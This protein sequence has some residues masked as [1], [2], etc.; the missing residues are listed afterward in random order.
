MMRALDSDKCLE[1]QD[2]HYLQKYR[3]KNHV[4]AGNPCQTFG[5]ILKF[6]SHNLS[7]VEHTLNFGNG[8]LL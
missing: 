6:I 4:R 2:T 3:G 1:L 8:L 5:G 7:V